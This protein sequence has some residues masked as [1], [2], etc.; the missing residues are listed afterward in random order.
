MRSLRRPSIGRASGPA[1]ALLA[2][3]VT[4]MS[5]ALPGEVV[6]S[7]VPGAPRVT[8][9]S[10]EEKRF[11]EVIRQH[12]DFS[13]GSAA[14]ATLLTYH[15]DRPTR[16]QEVFEAMWAAGDQAKISREGFSL[17]DMKRYLAARGL[18]ADGFRVPLGKLEAARIPAIALIDAGG[19]RHFVLIK[20]I[21]EERVLMADPA[22]GSKIIARPQFE[23]MWNGILFVLRSESETGQR[24]FDRAESWRVLAAAPLETA[25]FRQD[26]GSFTLNLPGPGEF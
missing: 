17:L 13:C 9:T 22:Q 5:P 1:L 8:L 10:I 12:Y 7:G 21:D 6:L 20:G 14:L 3:L 4:M 26:L 25:R 23:A 15:Y 2:G 11:G 18:A 24:H 19:Y 16:E